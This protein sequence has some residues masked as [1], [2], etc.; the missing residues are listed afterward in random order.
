MNSG[1]DVILFGAGKVS[2]HSCVGI[3]FN[4]KY[5]TL[6]SMTLLLICPKYFL[7]TCT[8]SNKRNYCFDNNLLNSIVFNVVMQVDYEPDWEIPV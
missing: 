3:V 8:L 2:I 7:H 6:E 4:V 1:L 5:M